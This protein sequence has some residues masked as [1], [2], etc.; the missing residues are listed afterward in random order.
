MKPR[1][2]RESKSGNFLPV[3]LTALFIST[4]GLSMPLRGLAAD[5]VD[6]VVKIPNFDIPPLG[7]SSE[8][9]GNNAADLPE[10]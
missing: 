4:T 7:S 1:C 2:R 9:I 8:K 6:P 3:N 10:R 5:M